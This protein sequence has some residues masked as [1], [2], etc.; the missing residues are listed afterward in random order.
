[1]N[2]LPLQPGQGSALVF[3]TVGNNQA[4]SEEPGRA[5]SERDDQVARDRT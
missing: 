3:T 4:I 2:R 1:V 5:S